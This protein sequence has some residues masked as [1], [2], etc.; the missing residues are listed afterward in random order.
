MSNHFPFSEVMKGNRLKD[1]R[2]IEARIRAAACADPSSISEDV[3]R[4]VVIGEFGEYEANHATLFMMQI[5][6]AEI[7][8]KRLLQDALYLLRQLKRAKYDP[9]EMYEV[10]VQVDQKV[11]VMGTIDEIVRAAFQEGYD[12]RKSEEAQAD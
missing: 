4:E 6:A 5:G 9:D 10:R 7:A 11:C 2:L 3:A 12:R 8:R 1:L